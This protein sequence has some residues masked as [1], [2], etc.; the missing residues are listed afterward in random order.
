VVSKTL[1]TGRLASVP[2]TVPIARRGK[3]A[4][5]HSMKI[6]RSAR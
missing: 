3:N 4:S 2:T 5:A 1:M 6:A